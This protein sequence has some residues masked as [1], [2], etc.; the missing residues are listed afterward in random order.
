MLELRVECLASLVAVP[1]LNLTM[2]RGDVVWLPSGSLK[3]SL[4]LRSF[5][6]V[7][8]VSV[9]ATSR[10]Q[11]TKPVKSSNPIPP[12]KVIPIKPLPLKED[13]VPS[14]ALTEE[15][16]ER[17]LNRFADKIISAVQREIRNL[18]NEAIGAA[19]IRAVTDAATLVPEPPVEPTISTEPVEPGEEVKRRGRKPNNP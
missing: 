16:L 6:E 1:D 15:R 11:T 3:Q 19:V 18:P 17:L 9:F 13:P 8:A 7:G 10:S 12:V 14:P 2:K 4:C 5:Q